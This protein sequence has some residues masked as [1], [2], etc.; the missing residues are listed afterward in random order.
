MVENDTTTMPIFVLTMLGISLVQHSKA[1]IDAPSMAKLHHTYSSYKYTP[2]Q[3]G[4]H[5]Q[6]P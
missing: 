3:H 1:E 5:S 6:C 4:F 2:N